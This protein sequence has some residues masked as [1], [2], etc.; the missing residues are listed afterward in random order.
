MRAWFTL[1]FSLQNHNIAG[2]PH[3][4][5]RLTQVTQHIAVVSMFGGFPTSIL[6][7]AVLALLA[8]LTDIASAQGIYQD[9]A[10]GD[11]TEFASPL[12]VDLTIYN[13]DLST[14][15]AVCDALPSCIGVLGGEFA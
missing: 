11:Y 6:M 12:K 1:L 4:Q 9:F 5:H 2:Y 15:K 3:S 10:I 13:P 7:A 8:S 14:G